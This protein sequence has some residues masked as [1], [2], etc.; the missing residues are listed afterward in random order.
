MWL[1]PRADPPPVAEERGAGRKERG[2]EEWEL[3]PKRTWQGGG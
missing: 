3:D 2:G 1:L